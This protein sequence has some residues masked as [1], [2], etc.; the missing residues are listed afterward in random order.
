MQPPR[1]KDG[2]VHVTDE[3]FN[4]ASHLIALVFFGIGSAT[5]VT[6]VATSGHPWLLVGVSLYA[7]GLCTL[8][9]FSTL[10]HCINGTPKTERI[11]QTLDYLA[12]Y[13]LIA[14]TFSPVCLGIV[15]TP[16]GWSVFGTVWIGAVVGMILKASIRSFPKWLGLC[17]YATLGWVAVFITIPVY[18]EVGFT[19]TS[20]LALGGFLYTLGGI[21]FLMERPNPYPGKF[22][23]HEI[24]HLLVIAGALCHFIF[25]RILVN[26]LI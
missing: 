3:R 22:G 12:I 13:L 20:L 6:K 24:W 8:F 1:S 7:F 16:L 4:T 15:R 25:I 10:H 2:S 23:F 26:S 9:L 18:K 14:G 19:A 21:L 11:L 17:L 5:L